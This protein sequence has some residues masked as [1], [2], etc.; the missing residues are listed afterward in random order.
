[1]QK[2]DRFVVKATKANYV[3]A[4]NSHSLT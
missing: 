4:G 3:K 1:M 2:I